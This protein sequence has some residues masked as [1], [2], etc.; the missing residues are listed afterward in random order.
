MACG[1]VLVELPGRHGDVSGRDQEKRIRISL[2]PQGLRA[3][4]LAKNPHQRRQLGRG[5]LDPLLRGQR[6]R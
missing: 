3:G 1:Q 6:T 5:E 4:Q 2:Q